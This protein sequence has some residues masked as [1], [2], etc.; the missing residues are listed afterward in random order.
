M[1]M[2]LAIVCALVSLVAGAT[3]GHAAQQCAV[4]KSSYDRALADY[5]RAESQ[6]NRLQNELDVRAEQGSYRR[7]MLEGNVEVARGN[8]AA[9][10]QSGFG[11][12][13][14]CFFIPR[15][16][17]IGSTISRTTQQAA[18]ARAQLRAQEGR[19]NA[20]NRAYEQQ[21]TRL[22]LRVAQQEEVV[23]QKKAI[24]DSEEA[25]YEACL[26]A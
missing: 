2:S 6:Y 12:A 17:C 7:A 5:N 10:N 21:M 11:Q 24:L 9:A 25:E 19:L 8:L 20:F 1:K 18:R 23:R 14:G 15:F 26:A 16:G 3:F 4:Q 13:V 22:S